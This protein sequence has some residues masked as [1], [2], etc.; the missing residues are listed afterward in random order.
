MLNEQCDAKIGTC[1]WQVAFYK[2]SVSASLIA[3]P[4]LQAANLRAAE[5][6]GVSSGTCI[7][8]MNKKNPPCATSVF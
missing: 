2:A 8:S 1:I 7:G 5:T 4:V 3:A 6:S